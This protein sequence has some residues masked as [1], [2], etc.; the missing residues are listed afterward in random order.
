[1]LQFCLVDVQLLA[2]YFANAPSQYFWEGE[3]RQAQGRNWKPKNGFE[4]MYFDILQVQYMKIECMY[5]GDPKI[6]YI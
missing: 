3:I 2:V 4:Y 6:Q 1:M 5:L